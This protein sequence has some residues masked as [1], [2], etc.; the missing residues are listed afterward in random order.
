ML[1]RDEQPLPTKENGSW[2]PHFP[3]TMEL[4]GLDAREIF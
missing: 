2:F 3:F 1:H 4:S